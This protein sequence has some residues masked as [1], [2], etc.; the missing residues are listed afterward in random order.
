MKVLIKNVSDIY[1]MDPERTHHYNADIL[2]D[3]SRI[4]NIGVNLSDDGVE[5]II[6]GRQKLAIPGLVNVHHHFYQNITRNIPIMQRGNLLQ[7]L[8]Y[9]YGAWAELEEEDVYA[10]ARLAAGELLLTGVTTS[11]DF[12]YFFPHKR[13]NLMDVEFQAAREMKLRFH[14]YR[15]CM[16]VM[17][18]ELPSQIQHLLHLDPHTMLET[19]E[20]ILTAC[21]D[22]SAK[23][24]DSSEGA[25]QRVGYGPTTVPFAMPE[26]MRDLLELAKRNDALLH[27]HFHPRPD[28]AA[29]CAKLYHM[30]PH[31]YMERTGW[32]SPRLSVAHISRHSRQQ[33]ELLAHY[34][35]NATHSPSCHM[36]LG[37]P[38]A[39]LIEAIQSG[40]NVGIGVDGGASNDS[41]DML[42][43][44]RTALYVHRIQGAHDG[45]PPESWMGPEDVFA[46]ATNNGARLLQRND[47]G[48]LEVGKMADIV[49]VNMNQIGY[50]SAMSDPLGALL[51][52]GNNHRVDTTIVNGEVVVSDGKLLCASEDK[53]VSE[54]NRITEKIMKSVHARTGIDFAQTE[55][56]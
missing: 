21:S 31:A 46:L 52:C 7:W 40:V 14:G 22:T 42:A 13:H 48:S 6:D 24:H 17:E 8:L 50:A 39:P 20:E 27:T 33:L 51:F 10:A 47:I 4:Q 9:S 2:I 26:F 54:A 55:R 15:G 16:P 34:G 32:L 53:I 45:Y 1:T 29:Y 25:M 11:M 19:P 43:E 18:G 44:L 36:R 38:V 35:V 30:T 5:K 12:M 37:Y 41:G 28:E 56:R 49:L 23:F 3:G